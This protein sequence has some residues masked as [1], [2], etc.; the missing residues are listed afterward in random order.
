VRYKTQIKR[1][2]D[3]KVNFT[4]VTNEIWKIVREYI[5]NIYSNKLE[6]LEKMD[7]VL[8]SYQS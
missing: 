7:T 6:N 4:K 8:E 3:E 5:E 1:I 2:Q